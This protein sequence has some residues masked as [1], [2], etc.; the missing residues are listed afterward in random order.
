MKRT[1]LAIAFGAGTLAFAGAYAETSSTSSPTY[2]G[3]PVLAPAGSHHSGQPGYAGSS[4]NNGAA[5]YGTPAQRRAG[6]NGIT[7]DRRAD[8]SSRTTVIDES[9]APIS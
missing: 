6:N 1:I 2:E 5:A 3:N 4:A 9:N 8:R 7:D